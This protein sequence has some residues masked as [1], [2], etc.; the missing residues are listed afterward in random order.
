VAEVV[1]DEAEMHPRFQQVRG[2]R[3]A[4]RV[5]RG[6]RVEAACRQGSAQ[7][8]L[9]AV[10]RHRGG[11]GGHPKTAPARSR[12]KPHGVA[13][14]G[15]GVAEQR[16]GLLGQGDRAVLRAF[17]IAHVDG[18]PGTSNIGDLQVGAF[19]ES[20]ATGIDGTQADA[21]PREPPTLEDRAHC[22]HAEDDR[23]RV[24][25]GGPHKGQRRPCPLEGMLV[26]KR[27]A[28]QRDGAGA[29]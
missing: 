10:A 6:A 25:L 22:L 8:V 29:A 11:G 24:L 12:K 27:D 17:A 16:E 13:M 21:L 28:A 23:E 7:G 1:L 9:D 20:Q 26:E 2:P 3:V 15:P 18:H 4:Q 19:L 14:G 5:H